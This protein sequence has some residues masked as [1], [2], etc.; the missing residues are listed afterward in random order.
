MLTKQTYSRNVRPTADWIYYV[1]FYREGKKIG[2]DYAEVPPGALIQASVVFY[3][4]GE[5]GYIE[6]D[7]GGI[8]SGWMKRVTGDWFW[9]T[10]PFSAGTEPGDY[11]YEAQMWFVMKL[12]DPPVLAD[13]K[14][15]YLKVVPGAPPAP[16]PWW[17]MIPGGWITLGLVG[18]AAG[19]LVV[20]GVLMYEERRKLEQQLLVGMR[21]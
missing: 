1:E 21:G 11:P 7:F 16:P 5:L 17:E 13:K 2:T 6:L 4:L 12:G 19:A 9:M 8:K 14:M 20:G 15:V 3:V 18:T 10:P